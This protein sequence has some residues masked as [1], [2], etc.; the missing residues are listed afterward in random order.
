MV[1]RV[2]WQYGCICPLQPSVDPG[3]LRRWYWCTPRWLVDTT[4]LAIWYGRT[5]AETLSHLTSY[6]AGP[7]LAGQ[8]NQDDFEGDWPDLEE[9]A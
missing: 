3:L 4:I 8:G 9:C 7:E 6:V 1:D 5:L 2:H